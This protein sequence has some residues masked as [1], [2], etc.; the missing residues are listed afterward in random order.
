MIESA[1]LLTSRLVVCDAH[2]RF[3]LPLFFRGTFAPFFRA[4][5][6]PMA[7][8]CLRLFTLPPLPPRPLLSVPFLRRRIALATRFPADLPY[9]R[10]LDFFLPPDFFLAAMVASSVRKLR[11]SA[12]R[13]RRLIDARSDGTA[14]KA[15]PAKSSM[16]REPHL[17]VQDVRP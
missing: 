8:A 10:P 2:E 17:L 4:S 7:I 9:F 16:K 1:G 11:K 15:V 13:S 5:D 3:F 14:S 6:S 12:R